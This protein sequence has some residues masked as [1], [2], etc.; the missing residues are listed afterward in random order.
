MTRGRGG[1]DAQAW[2]TAQGTK[3][4]CSGLGNVI[5]LDGNIG[6]PPFSGP[7]DEA[8]PQFADV[9]FHVLLLPEIQISKRDKAQA[10]RSSAAYVKYVSDDLFAGNTVSRRKLNFIGQTWR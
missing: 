9:F 7:G 3:E 1:R 8:M 6:M 10:K 4:N 5:E 2:V